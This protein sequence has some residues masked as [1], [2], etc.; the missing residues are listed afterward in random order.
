MAALCLLLLALTARIGHTAQVVYDADSGVSGSAELQFHEDP[1]GT[2]DLGAVRA[3]GT[4]FQQV[5][6]PV[7]NFGFTRSAYWL[8]LTLDNHLET[9]GTVYLSIPQPRLQD[10]RLFVLEDG[11]LSQTQRTGLSLPAAE[12]PISTIHPVLPIHLEPGHHYQL[13]V[14]VAGITAALMVPMQFQTAATVDHLSQRSLLLNGVIC[15]VFISLFIYN[16]FIFLTLREGAYACYLVLLPVAFLAC[17][18]LNGFGPWMLYPHW[19]WPS[20][21]GMPLLAGGAFLLNVLFTRTLLDTAAVPWLDRLLRIFAAACVALMLSPWWLPSIDAFRFTFS[22]LFVAPAVGTLSGVVS[23]RRGHAQARFFLIA[24]LAAWTA[25][26]LYGLVV[27]GVIPFNDLLRQ[28]VTLGISAETLMM[29]LAL[30]ERIRLLQASTHRA[31][32]AT[33]QA[34]AA[35]REQLERT[36]AERTRELDQAR[37]HAEHLATTDA[38]TG[39]LNRRGLL[40][41]LQLGIQQALREHEPLALISFDIDHFKRI[42]DDFGHAEGDRVLRLLVTLLSGLVRGQDLLGR[43]GGEEFM[44]ALRCS[45]EAAMELAERLRAQIEAHLHAGAERR[46][47]TASFGVAMASYALSNLDALQRAADAALYRAKNRGRNRVE[48]YDEDDSDTARTRAIMHSSAR[49]RFE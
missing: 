28:T 4:P 30:T 3:A 22:L 46:V 15:G 7:A 10:V 37:R 39:V 20:T 25:M 17:C 47:V 38:L 2:Q 24:R 43:T 12:H 48:V 42:N 36:V 40:P 31:E 16:L 34:L 23:L 27:L 35:Q 26:V 1:S 41:L 8:R 14:R 49:P 21:T 32:E 44:L 13:Y 9:A 11:V 29:S 45:R 18:S 19:V 5:L 6:T 33:R